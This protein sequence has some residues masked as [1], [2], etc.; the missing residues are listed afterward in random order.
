MAQGLPATQRGTDKNVQGAA[1]AQGVAAFAA[2]VPH[3]VATSQMKEL[4]P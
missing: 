3:R 1:D 4:T 2:C